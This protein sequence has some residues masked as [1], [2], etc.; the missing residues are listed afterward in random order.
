V[1]NR[2][3]RPRAKILIVTHKRIRRVVTVDGTELSNTERY[4]D[5]FD[6][7]DLPSDGEDVDGHD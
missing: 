1:V 7:S 4:N 3:K 5:L 6:L 2:K